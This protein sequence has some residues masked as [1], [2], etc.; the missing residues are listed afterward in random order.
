MTGRLTSEKS[1]LEAHWERPD[2]VSQALGPPRELP[3]IAR[4]PERQPDPALS[5]GLR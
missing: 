5:D 4:R 1:R 2:L 3:Q